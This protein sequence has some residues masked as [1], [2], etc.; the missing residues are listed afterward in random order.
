MNNLPRAGPRAGFVGKIA[1]T[2]IRAF[3]D[4]DKLQTHVLV[5]GSTGS[6]KSITAQDIAEEALIK[7]ASVI[8]FDPTA[9]WT[10]FLRKCNEKVMLSRYDFFD[11]K[12]KDTKAFKGNIRILTDPDE[13][14][15]ITKYI[16]PGEITVFSMHKLDVK[17]IDKA[18]A[19]LNIAHDLG[20]E[21]TINIMAASV[22]VEKDLIESLDQLA[23]TLKA[24]LACGGTIKEHRIE[25]QGEHKPRVRQ[26][27]IESGFAPE[28][29]VVK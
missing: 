13:A 27:L 23:K 25:L 10:G 20:Y 11:M 14:I 2:D 19:M 17:D 1:E 28:T 6:G 12:K 29:I 26:I 16:V 7:N 5:A 18:I 22:E 24:R 8:V 3:I 4:M 9:Q 21:T 15:D